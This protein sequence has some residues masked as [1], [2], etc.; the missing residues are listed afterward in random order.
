MS[1][2]IEKHGHG[3]SG[4]RNVFL[5]ILI[6]G[7]AGAATVLLLAP[8]SG[9]QTRNQIRLKSIQFRDQ[10]AEEMK[11]TFA[12]VRSKTQTVTDGIR[13]KSGQ[14]KHIGQDKLVKQLDRASAAVKAAQDR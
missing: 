1:I 9:K 8:Q 6:G 11:N 5:G 4:I 14:L 13:E 7:L 3:M 2:P 12:H 10:A